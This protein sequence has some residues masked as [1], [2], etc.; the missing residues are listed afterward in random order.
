MEVAAVSSSKQDDTTAYIIGAVFAVLVLASILV[1]I[2]VQ[3]QRHQRSLM[4]SQSH[5]DLDRALYNVFGVKY[6][7]LVSRAPFPGNRL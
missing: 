1:L 4:A 5:P 7:D 2:V 6:I 3:Y